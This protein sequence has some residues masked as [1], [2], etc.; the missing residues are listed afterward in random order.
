MEISFSIFGQKKICLQNSWPGWP[1]R[2]EQARNSNDK[3]NGSSSK[4]AA[5]LGAVALT[6]TGM[7]T[8]SATRGHL[9]TGRSHP[10]TRQLNQLAMT[11]CWIYYY[12]Y[13]SWILANL[14]YGHRGFFLVAFSC[15]NSCINIKAAEILLLPAMVI[16]Q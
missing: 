10:N 6:G 7:G 12:L 1:E 5:R 8:G 11:A 13:R 9:D 2:K 15:W 3:P 4:T 14:I 16:E